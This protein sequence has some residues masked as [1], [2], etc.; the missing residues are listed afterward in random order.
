[1]SKPSAP[2]EQ[3]EHWLPKGVYH[4]VS[5]HE[6]VWRWRVMP[7]YVALCGAMVATASLRGTD[8]RTSVSTSSRRP[9]PVA[10][11]ACAQPSDKT[12]GPESTPAT[13]PW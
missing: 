13:V 11:T 2:Y 5:A 7:R 9:W 1:V 8:C 6:T 12:T 4:L 10:R 3:D